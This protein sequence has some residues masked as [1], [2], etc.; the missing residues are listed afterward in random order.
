MCD[1]FFGRWKKHLFLIFNV[2]GVIDVR[3]TAVLTPETLVPELS[4]FQDEMCIEKLQGHKL[5]DTDQIPAEM[6]KVGGRTIRSEI[7]KL[8]TQFYLEFGRS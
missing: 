4:D 3:Q 7:H 1:L 5:P 2:H 6:I 8:I